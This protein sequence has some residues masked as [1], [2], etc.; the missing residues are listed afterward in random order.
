MNNIQPIWGDKFINAISNSRMGIN[1][2]RG[3]PVKYYS[4]DRIVQLMGNGLLTFIDKKTRYNDFFSKN[5]MIFYNDLDDL[6]YKLNK[7]KKDNKIAKKIAQNGRAAYI[8]KFNSTI[9]ADFI[10]SKT[11][12]YKSKNNFVWS[13]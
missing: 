2:S 4:S 6:G 8:K 1:L 13:K 5:E 10:L 7:Y 11:L 12:D 9:V 3:E